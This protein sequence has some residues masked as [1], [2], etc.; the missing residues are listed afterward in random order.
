MFHG[1]SRHTPPSS[2]W[3]CQKKRGRPWGSACNRWTLSL[4]MLCATSVGQ[5]QNLSFEKIHE[6]KHWTWYARHDQF[7]DHKVEIKALFGYADKAFEKLCESWGL[8]P[9][10]E[11][12][13]LLVMPRPGG[14]FAAGDIGEVR[15][16]TG[17]RSPGIG[18]SYDAFFGTANGIKA[19]WA[20]ILITHEMVNLF[21]GQIVSGGWP[22]DWGPITAVPSP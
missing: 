17:K 16:I 1:L 13:A 20:H 2:L 21:T 4:L 18:C 9:P 3:T 6:G 5:A 8:R 15:S 7:Q 22:V 10:G 11:K 19:Y 14:G 12:Y